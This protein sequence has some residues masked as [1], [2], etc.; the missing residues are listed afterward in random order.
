MDSEKIKIGLGFILICIIWGST[1]LF[2]RLG[3]ESLTPVISA[4]IRFLLA[5]ILVYGLMSYK[6]IS[7]QTDSLSIRLYLVLAFFSFIIPFGLVYWAEQFIPSGLA[8]IIFAVM[9]FGVILF[10]RIAIPNTEIKLAQYIG[11]II[12]FVGIVTIFSEDLTIDISNNFFGMLAVLISAT[13]QASIAVTIKKYGSHLNPL[14][15]NFIPLLI[16]GFVMIPLAFIIEDS[17]LWKFDFIAIVSVFYL[18][19]FGTLVTFT[20]YYWLLKRMNIVILSL[21]TFITPIVAV[22]LGWFILNE[23]FSFQA[24]IGSAMVLIGILFAN[25]NGLKKYIKSR[26]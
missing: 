12:G 4:G 10:T 3:L 8:S 6:K 22:I 19:L 2:I 25:F 14:S 24:L 11:V 1:W 23:K 13:M 17:A 5:S 21:S 16:A 9:P 7:L 15:M 18:A 26:K 20:T